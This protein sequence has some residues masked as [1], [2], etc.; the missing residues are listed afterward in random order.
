MIIWPDL[1]I[2][3]ELSCIK[4]FTILCFPIHEH[5]IF[6]RHFVKVKILSNFI[7]AKKHGINIDD[8][9]EYIH[10]SVYLGS[11]SHVGLAPGTNRGQ[12]TIVGV[13][14]LD[15]SL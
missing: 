9:S 11:V 4:S 7:N 12:A 13:I 6:A 14:L 10:K 5:F 2:D 15:K 1:H 3:L 8:I